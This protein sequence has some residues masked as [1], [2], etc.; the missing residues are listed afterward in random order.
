MDEIK[1][2]IVDIKAEIFDII[3][4]QE[5]LQ[6]QNE[7]LKQSKLNLVVKLQ[8]LENA[9]PETIDTKVSNGS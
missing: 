1:K 9:P 4:E 3:R 5:L 8:E 6:I 7:K 2:Q